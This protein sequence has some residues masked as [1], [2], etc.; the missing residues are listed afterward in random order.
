MQIHTILTHEN[1]DLDAIMSCLLMKT[2]GEEKIPGVATAEIKFVSANQL[3]ENK[4]SRQ[5]EKE[6]I[7]TVDTGGGR[8]DT[9]PE[10]TKVDKSKLDRSATDLV[11]EFVGVLNHPDWKDLVE[12]TRLHD[13]SGHSLYSKD[14]LHHLVTIQTVLFGFQLMYKNDSAQK[15]ESG[16]KVLS[17]IPHYVKNRQSLSIEEQDKLLIQYIN[18]YLSANQDKATSPHFEK[19]QEWIDRLNNGADNT[20]P[21]HELDQLITL[22]PICLGA[23]F[24]FEANADKVQE[25]LGLCLEAILTREQ[26][27]TEAMEK[28][29]E[30]RIQKIDKAKVN[31]ISSENGLVIKASRFVLKSDL[32]IYHNPDNGAVSFIL[33]RYGKFHPKLLKKITAII[34]IAECIN[35]ENHQPDYKKMEYYGEVCGWFFHQSGSFLSKGSLKA[36][37]F[38]I[39]KIPLDDIFELSCAEASLF[40]NA[41]KPI[42]YPAKYAQEI[43]KYKL[44]KAFSF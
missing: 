13:S 27:W 24:K 42:N 39:T 29:Q 7:I 37:K 14:P 35:N 32:T 26:K 30:S 12:Y 33:K 1:P 34:R 9:H 25:I 10:G 8:F 36:N 40:V 17:A 38:E 5:L 18:Q 15:L 19:I 28:V 3:P 21:Q 4:T 16:T 20:Y 31:F 44:S 43:S 6:G 23:H 41:K 22:K 11:A 2:F